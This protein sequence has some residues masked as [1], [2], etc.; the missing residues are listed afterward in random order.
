MIDEGQYLD[1][2]FP[3]LLT[4]MT[5]EEWV[6][7]RETMKKAIQDIVDSPSV[8]KEYKLPDERGVDTGTYHINRKEGRPD[9]MM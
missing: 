9:I 7:I 5:Y 1:Y 2:S 6:K 4:D 3:H 8:P